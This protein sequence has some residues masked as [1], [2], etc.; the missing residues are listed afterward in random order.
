[1]GLSFKKHNYKKPDSRFIS[2]IDRRII[3]NFD[4]VLLGMVTLIVIIG[5]VNLYSTTHLGES[6]TRYDKMKENFSSQFRWA[7]IGVLFLIVAFIINYRLFE[8][9]AYWVYFTFLILLV[10]VLIFG[11]AIHGAKR[12]LVM[13]GLRFQPSELAKIGLV[14][15]LAKYL[16]TNKVPKGYNFRELII[17]AGIIMVP[18]LLILKEPDLGTA[19]LFILIGGSM[20]I[21]SGIRWHT[22][23]G[24]IVSVGLLVPISWKFFLRDYQRDR[25]LTWLNPEMDPSAKGYHILQSLNAIGSGEF[26]GKGFL[27][28]TQD[29]LGFL[30]EPHTDFVFAVFAEEWGFFGC[31]ILLL[32]YFAIIVWSMSVALYSKDRF[33]AILAVGLVAIIFWHTFINIAMVI[34]LAPVVG[35]PLPFMSY[36]R[37]S[38]ITM[39][40]VVGLLLNVSSRRYVF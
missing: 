27:N 16:S 23:L 24:L 19:M 32:L 29:K 5:L 28:S 13:A 4:W 31:F 20:L 38:L 12:W 7:I 33:A 22:L 2:K 34:G 10:G 15:A 39:M 6:D 40:I 9:M 25:L 11:P 8:G 30:P 17:P 14:L 1:M 26:F 21:F 37:S 36:G 3:A 18:T 35:M